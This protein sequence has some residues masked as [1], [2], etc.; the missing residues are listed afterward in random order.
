LPEYHNPQ[1][2]PG[3]EKRLLLV[4]LLTFIGIAVMQYLMPKPPASTQPKPAQQAQQEQQ[5]S[6]AP[7]PPVVVKPP[8]GSTQAAPTRQGASEVT[9]TVEN[10]LYRIAFSNKGGL[11]RS[12]VLKQYKND[13]GQPLDIVNP[14]TAPVLGYPLSLHTYDPEL[15]KKLN[16]ALYVPSTTGKLSVPNSLTYEFSDGDTRVRKSFKFDDHSYVVG[17]E[18]EVV[19]K[20]ATVQASPQWAGGF[21]DQTV[22]SSYAGSRIDWL[23]NDEV[24]RKPAQ[25]G[26]FFTG[27]KWVVGGQTINGPFQWV[28]TVDQYF[29]AIF[30]PESPQDAA[31]VTLHSQVDIPKN[32]DKPEEGGKDKA[33]VLGI[34]IGNPKGVTRER[35]FV[36]PKT[37]DVLESTKAQPN[38]P[39]LRQIIDFGFFGFIA[40]PLFVCLKW[41]HN[42][43]LHNWG[44]DIA[45]LTLVINLV[46]L[47]L[48]ISQIKSGLKMQKIQPQVKAITEKY[49]R[50]GI[51][52]PRRAEMQKEMSALYK[53]EGVNPVGGCFPLLLTM[54]FLFAF[55]SVLGNAVELRQANWLWIHDLSARDPLHLLPILIVLTMFVSQ[56]SS[57]QPGMDPAQQKMLQFMTP[58][59]M[60]LV[61][62][63]LASG[64]GVYW[65]ITNIL[66]WIQQLVINQ[67]E[68]GKQMRKRRKR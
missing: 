5:Q 11:V 37:V 63:N 60:G 6:P 56:Q 39:D 31:L 64:V 34:A 58:V 49:K 10:N 18:T 25:S 21:G 67:T 54:P 4:F 62:W 9:T 20:G 8:V 15:G 44:W 57:P 66:G 46:M 16:E 26:W 23:Q 17:V 61:S 32:L 65:A 12:W 38:G 27:K 42:N 2:E 28:G 19:N 52:D 43:F 35:L 13:K 51:T 59:M 53:K 14:V 24:T 7:A 1:Q 30:M 45:F 36:G 33:S 68:F 41:I 22:L 3:A 29:A 48:R 40:R 47:P 50:Y 55:Y